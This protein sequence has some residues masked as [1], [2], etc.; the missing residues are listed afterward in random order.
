MGIHVKWT[1]PPGNLANSR[2]WGI[3]LLYLNFFLYF[4]NFKI[5]WLHQL[6][7]IL[8]AIKPFVVISFL[9]SW[10]IYHGF[11]AY[12]LLSEGQ[13][14]DST[15]KRNEECAGTLQ[16]LEWNHHISFFMRRISNWSTIPW[17]STLVSFMLLWFL[18]PL[19]QYLSLLTSRYFANNASA[20]LILFCPVLDVHWSNDMLRSSS[21]LATLHHRKWC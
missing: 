20:H 3:H 13:C 12:Y 19:Q 6:Q 17:A 7:N 15:Y 16:E 8:V 9:I 1:L 2:I 14:W 18:V 11:S 10:T 4:P 5:L 21:S